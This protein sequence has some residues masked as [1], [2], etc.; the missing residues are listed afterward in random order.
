MNLIFKEKQKFTQW[1]LWVLLIGILMIPSYGI[2]KQIIMGEQF[3]DNPLPNFGLI[4]F[5]IF[6]LAFIVFFWMLQLTTIINDESIQMKYFPF[7]NKEIKWADIESAEVIDYGFVGGWG[8]RIG[9]KYGTVYNTSGK[10]GL[11]LQLKNGKKLC[12]GTQKE[13][14]LIKVI[15]EAYQQQKIQQKKQNQ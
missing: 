14:E 12:I 1:W 4:I 6:M 2:Y 7:S 10:I 9:T 5:F 8:V 15:K 3:G 13:K 11:A